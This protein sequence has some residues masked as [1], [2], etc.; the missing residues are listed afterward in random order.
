MAAPGVSA[1]IALAL[2][3]SPARA[4]EACESRGRVVPAAVE[5]TGFV[6]AGTGTPF[7]A[8]RAGFG[9]DFELVQI[10]NPWHYG[11]PF[12]LRLGP[13]VVGETQLDRHLLEGGL[14]LDVGQ[15]KHASF[16]TYTLRIGGGI[17]DDRRPF[18]SLTVL[19][20]V[21]YVLARYQDE[22]ACPKRKVAFSSGARVF[23][24]VRLD[25]D[26]R[27]QWIIGIELEPT[28]ALPPYSRGKLMGS[29]PNY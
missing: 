11:G 27:A 25:T 8:I 14:A 19:G 24:T 18:G 4:E 22:Y 6:G 23:G 13:W 12:E 26:E 2:I 15:T 16:G 3:A 10:R 7:A 17:D 29:R 20:G 21:R 5:W 28:W 1:A 9:V